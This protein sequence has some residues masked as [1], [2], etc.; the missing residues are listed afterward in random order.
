MQGALVHRLLEAAMGQLKY[1]T[2]TALFFHLE[3]LVEATGR[4]GSVG[5]Q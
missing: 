2:G 5:Y 4:L 1:V 3:C